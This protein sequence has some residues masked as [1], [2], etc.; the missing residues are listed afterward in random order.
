M[1]LLLERDALR[2]RWRPVLLSSHQSC[3]GQSTRPQTLRSNVACW[4]STCTLDS[5]QNARGR[6]R[7]AA[8]VSELIAGHAIAVAAAP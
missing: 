5:A 4:T 8:A 1:P 7:G 2:L 6:G 3:Q